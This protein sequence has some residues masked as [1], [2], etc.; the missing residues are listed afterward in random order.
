MLC[1]GDVAFFC[2]CL[3]TLENF[4]LWEH[5]RNPGIPRNMD[6]LETFEFA[7]VL[8]AIAE[9]QH[10]TRCGQVCFTETIDEVLGDKDMEQGGD[11]LEKADGEA[12]LLEEIP[13]PGFDFVFF[14][15]LVLQ[16]DG[17][18]ATAIERST[19]ANVT[20]CPSS[21]RSH[22]CRQ[23]FPMPKMRQRNAET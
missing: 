2:N 9:N 8:G 20:C 21:T 14:V 19:R 4:R 5:E 3:V 16:P 22:Q 13:L 12:D 7:D 17:N 6:D 15:E 23:D 10:L 1:K 18:I 11:T